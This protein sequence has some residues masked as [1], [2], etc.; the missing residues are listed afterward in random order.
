M[1][2]SQYIKTIASSMKKVAELPRYKHPADLVNPLIRPI[3]QQNME[4][5]GEIE[6]G[7]NSYE[8]I[9]H[10][11]LVQELIATRNKYRTENIANRLNYA[12]KEYT[13]WNDYLKQLVAE[14]PKVS[15]FDKIGRGDRGK[16][17]Q[18]GL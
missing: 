14:I 18:Q 6:F 1:S 3:R 11:K 17:T 5:N 8:N 7:T 16:K 10:E 9:A 15:H 13:L 4:I 2:Q 12:S